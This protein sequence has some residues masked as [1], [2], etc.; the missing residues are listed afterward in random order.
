MRRCS[1]LWFGFPLRLGALQ[2]NRKTAGARR[3]PVMADSAAAK[4][5]FGCF[6]EIA[7]RNRPFAERAVAARVLH[8]RC[9]KDCLFVWWTFFAGD[10]ATPVI[11]LFFVDLNQVLVAGL[12]RE[13]NPSPRK[14]AK[15][16]IANKIAGNNTAFGR[17]PAVS[18]SARW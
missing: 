14:T 16:F 5:G 17:V 2:T 9:R 18:L 7:E 13:S 11:F 1:G 12:G 10:S 6:H 15:V 3:A 4:P 8:P